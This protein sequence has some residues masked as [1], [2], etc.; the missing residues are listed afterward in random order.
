MKINI[1]EVSLGMLISGECLRFKTCYSILE[2]HLSFEKFL[3]MLILTINISYF[4]V[5]ML[6]TCWSGSNIYCMLKSTI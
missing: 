1:F 3:N 6:L 5:R 2:K 4:E